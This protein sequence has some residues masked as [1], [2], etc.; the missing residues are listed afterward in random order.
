MKDKLFVDCNIFLDMLIPRKPYH[1]YATELLTYIEE[2]KI[3]GYTSPL[4]FSNLSYVLRKEK[5]RDRA[6]NDLRKIRLFLKIL[7]VNE[8]IIDLALASEFNDF[9]DAVHYY[10]AMENNVNYII[11]RNKK[12]YKKSEIL[13]CD[14]KEYLTIFKSKTP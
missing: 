10:T 2:E 7:P 14:P 11:T 8:K 4:I 9:E 6:I 5:I 12:D 3:I 13:I 1:D